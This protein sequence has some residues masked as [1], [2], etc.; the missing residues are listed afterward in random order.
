MMKKLVIVVLVCMVCSL[1]Q[2]AVIAGY[3]FGSD[4]AA[5]TEGANVTASAI[6]LSA[7]LAGYGGRSGGA[8]GHLYTRSSGTGVT[9]LAG[10]ITDNDYLTFTI[11]VAAGYE[12][13][14]TSLTL[15]QG[16]TRNS[17]YTGK[18]LTANLLTSVDGFSSADSVSD[19]TSWATIKDNGSTP[20]FQTW[21]IDSEFSG[22]KFQGL[23][24]STEFRFY[25]TD[26]TND[27]NIIHRF[28]DIVLNGTV[29]PEP[30]TLCLLGLGGLLSLKRRRN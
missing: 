13:N 20:H 21:T 11:D 18:F 22:A 23:T 25:L 30:A 3:N 7:G 8:G 19:I 10:A 9:D 6:G 5:T 2:G 14:L 15:L 17:S 4:L 29:I 16:Y 1:S 24:G 27:T 26:N 28:D 12:M